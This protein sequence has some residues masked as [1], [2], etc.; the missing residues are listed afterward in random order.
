MSICLVMV[1]GTGLLCRDPRAPARI[2]DTACQVYE[3]I[4]W[5]VY[6][7]DQTIVLIRQHNAV[8]DGL[9]AELPPD[10]SDTGTR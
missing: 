9:C 10:P 4:E 3:P 8:Y 6:D 5:S 2:V 1:L 7:T